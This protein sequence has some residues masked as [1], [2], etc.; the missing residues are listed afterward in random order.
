MSNFGAKRCVLYT[1]RYGSTHGARTK[2]GKNTWLVLFTNADTNGS[3]DRRTIVF[4]LNENNSFAQTR[5]HFTLTMAFG[6]TGLMLRVLEEMG[7]ILRRSSITRQFRH[8]D[9]D[10][11]NL[12]KEDVC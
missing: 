6:G 7:R 10:R 5:R 4:T 12:K 1:R 3:S 9:R 11:M 2:R 8:D